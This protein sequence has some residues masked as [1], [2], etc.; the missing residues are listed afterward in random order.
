[1]P[2][3]VAFGR[4]FMSSMEHCVVYAAGYHV[5]VRR[6]SHHVAKQDLRQRRAA[7]WPG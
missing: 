2:A 7:R 1:M 6:R 3:S 4:M 5:C